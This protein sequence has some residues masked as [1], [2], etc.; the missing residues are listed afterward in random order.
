MN[1]P[2]GNPK[3]YEFVAKTVEFDATPNGFEK[4]LTINI[5][6]DVVEEDNEDIQFRIV[7]PDTPKND[8]GDYYARDP[9]GSTAT[10]TLTS[11]D[12]VEAVTLKVNRTASGTGE[13]DVV[14]GS[15]V[16]VTATANIPV[17]P[18]GWRIAT[19][20][21]YITQPPYG[22]MHGTISGGC[23]RTGHWPGWACPNDY[24][25]PAAFT[26]QEGQTEATATLRLVSDS[27][28]EDNEERLKLRATATR[29][30]RTLTTNSLDLHIS[31]T[32]AGVSVSAPT[33]DLVPTETAT[34][35]V[36]LRGVQP[37]QNVT[38]TPTS[39]DATKATATCAADPCELTFTPQNWEDAQQITVTAVAVGKT[40]ITHAATSTDT[41]YNGLSSLG[42]VVVTVEAAAQNFRIEPSAAAS[43]GESA[44]LRVTLGALA[45]TGG[46]TFTV[47]RSR[48]NDLKYLINNPPVRDPEDGL[49]DPAA[50]LD[51]PPATVTVPAG[52]RT[53][54]ITDPIA[55]DERVEGDE[56]YYVVISTSTSGWSPVARSPSSTNY[57]HCNIDPSFTSSGDQDAA[58]ARV[59]ID[60]ADNTAMIAFGNS[61]TAT[62]IYTDSVS[63]SDATLSVPVTVSALPASAT[64]FD[65]DVVTTGSGLATE[66]TD[67]T[68]AAKSVTFSPTDSTTTKNITITTTDDDV[69]EGDETI[70][71]RIAAGGSGLA[72]RYQR[73]P[74]GTQATVTISDDD[75]A[76]EVSAADVAVKKGTTDTYK[77]KLAG[78]RP[79]SNVTVDVASGDGAT[80]TVNP[81]RLTFT[82]GNWDRPQTVTV[83][84]VAEGST[85]ITHTVGGS[86]AAYPSDLSVALV[87][88]RVTALPTASLE[89]SP[90]PV[91]EGSSVTVTVVLSEAVGTVKTLP[92]LL[93]RVTAEDGDYDTLAN[94]A[95][96]P[97]STRHTGTI[98]TRHDADTDNEEFTVALTNLPSSLAEGV[99]IKVKVIIEDDDTGGTRGP[100]GTGGGGGG[101]GG[102]GA[103][104]EAA[105]IVRLWGAD[106]YATSLAVAREVAALS[107]DRLPAVVLAGGRSWA[108][109]LTA[110][111]LAGRLGGAVLLTPPDGLGADAVGW[112]GEV[113]VSEIIAVGTAE[114]ISD[115]ALVALADVDADIERIA[116]ADRSAAS[117][118]VARRIG[119]PGSL[120]PQLGRTVIVAS[121]NVFADALA[122]GPLAAQKG[123]PILLVGPSNGLSDDARAY[124][125]EFADHVIIMGGTAAVTADTEAQI[126]AI[127]QAGRAATSMGVTRLGGSD[128]YGT[129]ARLARWLN[130]PPIA[131]HVCFYA[132]RTGLATGLN[133]ADA[134]ASAP[135]LAK[136]CA[137]LVLTR[138]DIIPPAT[139]SYLRKTAELIIF[140]GPSAIGH[141]TIDSW[142]E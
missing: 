119:A 53:V 84:G 35:T 91:R 71:L 4:T 41:T 55:T 135:L 6:D 69:A 112:L 66:G 12:R 86:D 61:A 74:N 10:V 137:P 57:Q 90:N 136:R 109:A 124:L 122:A 18:N 15:N 16:T 28:M 141:T 26:I 97:G 25:L 54:T 76:V 37:T 83:R 14:E 40:T 82:P 21:T 19:E 111:A 77:I 140:G 80:A 126:Q 7:A 2:T 128:R 9:N 50:D 42:P 47:D 121:S 5:A 98:R 105:E 99:P 38:I 107:G 92:V 103:S 131:D 67:Y 13:F 36:S 1:N 116:A 58:C 89:I 45:P 62:T 72:A 101:G 130:N 48:T 139:A 30:T 100:T 138:P 44:E 24:R 34:Y 46:L 118:A 11:E 51:S 22:G 73:D 95:I 134:A 32:N 56:H 3:D 102:G 96:N 52:K 142:N 79:A 33:F 75:G 64:T 43:E 127:P 115:D 68:I 49:A 63:E 120:G 78:A 87:N 31:D 117:V 133:P 59:D 70:R 81:T 27:R 106:R 93:T 114:H 29:G 60:D 123:L 8:L 94:I 104:R 20:N 23:Q 110:G 129:A 125:A 108:D 88:V 65:I 85:T 39:S 17:G 132:D 113:G